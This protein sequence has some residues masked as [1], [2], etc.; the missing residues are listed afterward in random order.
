MQHDH[1]LA[2]SSAVNDIRRRLTARRARAD[3]LAPPEWPP[4]RGPTP[5]PRRH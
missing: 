2:I 4:S 5:H 1:H 3:R